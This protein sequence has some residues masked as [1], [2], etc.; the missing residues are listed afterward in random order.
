VQLGAWLCDVSP[1]QGSGETDIVQAVI[2]AAFAVGSEPLVPPSSLFDCGG[3]S[4]CVVMAVDPNAANAQVFIATDG[5]F[6][7]S[8]NNPPIAHV[9]NMVLQR[10]I[11]NQND[12]TWVLDPSPSC[13]SFT[14]VDLP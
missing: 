14:T 11:V 7:L 5:T 1:N 6:T 3:P 13:S 4:T 2:S 8:Q 9:D 10:I 12:G